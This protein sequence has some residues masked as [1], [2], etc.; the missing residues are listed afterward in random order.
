[1]N[2]TLADTAARIVADS[3]IN[4]AHPEPVS[5]KPLL[6]KMVAETGVA[7][8]TAGL[9]LARAIASRMRYAPGQ[10]GKPMVIDDHT[11]AEQFDA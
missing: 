10:D 2:Q 3:G 4:F 6:Q 8:D 11:P 7:E 9:H 5:M 1:M